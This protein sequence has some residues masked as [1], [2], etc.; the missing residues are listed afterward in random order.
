MT[1]QKVDL[2][3]ELLKLLTVTAQI[4]RAIRL[5]SAY[6]PDSKDN[7]NT[8]VNVMEL[9]NC[10]HNFDQLAK[11]IKD[12]DIKEI[13]QSCEYLSNEFLI[14]QDIPSFQHCEHALIEAIGVFKDIRTKVNK[15]Y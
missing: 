11:V 14:C 3:E 15:A 10:L 8:L 13:N 5:N 12:N 1:V 9:S 6:C 4:A 7:P 2:S